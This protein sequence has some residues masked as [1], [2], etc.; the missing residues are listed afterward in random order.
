MI[1]RDPETF[2]VGVLQNWKTEA[3]KQ[4]REELGKRLVSSDVAAVEMLTTALTG[5]PKS[6][7][8]K[9]IENAALASSAALE[10]LD[11]RF[12]VKASYADGHTTFSLMAQE[13]LN[14]EL[15]VKEDYK[16]EFVEKYRQLLNH[17]TPM[18]IS[19]DA[20]AIAG[21]KLLEEIFSQT[22]NG[23]LEISSQPKKA[24]I[25]KFW[26]V[27]PNAEVHIVNDLCGEITFGRESFSISG[28][29]YDGLLEVVSRQKHNPHVPGA[30]LTITVN[31]R[32]W[33][34]QLLSE[35]PNFDQIYTL[36]TNLRTGWTFNT[37]VEIDG[38]EMFV[39][40]GAKLQDE[41]SIRT[42]FYLLRYIFLAREVMRHLGT[43]IRFDPDYNYDEKVFDLLAEIHRITSVGSV[44]KVS[45][46][47]GN[48]TCVLIAGEDVDAL[49]AVLAVA[50]PEPIKFTKGPFNVDLFNQ[51]VALPGLSYTLTKV[52]PHVNEDISD[53]KPGQEVPIE[54]KPEEDCEMVSILL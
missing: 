17:G 21:S 52:R 34:N 43:E 31:F 10:A 32:N 28:T 44:C 25:Q 16:Q 7:L 26:L 51:S 38:K 20:I 12:K 54:W 29:A 4:A 24:A 41:D 5:F 36:F 23:I 27:G 37:R 49:K 45:E 6:F 11:P 1:D 40:K 48:A 47:N 50:N 13:N 3:E 46:V 15:Q 53:L 9:A 19:S 42:I 14:F 39:G 22:E 33:A 35:L 8:P 2:K 30:K 18:G